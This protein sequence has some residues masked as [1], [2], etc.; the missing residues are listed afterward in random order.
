MPRSDRVSRMAAPQ[1]AMAAAAA[2]SASSSVAQG[3]PV[4]SLSSLRLGVMKLAPR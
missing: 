1:C 2:H 3:R 4:A